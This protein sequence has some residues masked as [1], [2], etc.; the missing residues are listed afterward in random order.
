MSH[1]MSSF[2]YIFR[3]TFHVIFRDMSYVKNCPRSCKD[4][5]PCVWSKTC[6]I[7]NMLYSQCIRNLPLVLIVL[8][9][10]D[11]H[12]KRMFKIY[13]LFVLSSSLVSKLYY[14]IITKETFLLVSSD[15]CG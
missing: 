10:C 1:K 6:K 9:L 5:I 11:V 3:D 7:C 8:K 14:G 13:Q 12:K 2:G 15:P 4:C